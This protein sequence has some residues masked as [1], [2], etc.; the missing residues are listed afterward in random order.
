VVTVLPARLEWL[1]ALS[2]G[3]ETFTAR[4]GIPVVA[5]WVGFPDALPLAVDGARKDPGN[6]WGTHLFFDDQ[7]GALVGF[8]GWKDAPRAGIV[9][10]GYAVAPARQ[11][12]GIATDVVRELLRRA[13]EA[14]VDMVI[15]HTLPE[16]SASTA[17]LHKCGFTRGA[18]SADPDEGTVWRWEM[19]LDAL[20]ERAGAPAREN[21]TMTAIQQIPVSTIDGQQATLADHAGKVLLIVNVASKCGLTPQYEQLES[22]YRDRRDEG[23]EVL[24]FPANN[25]AGQEPGSNDEIVEFCESNYSV[26]FPLFS[27][28]SVTGDDKHPLYEALTE[29]VPRA[30]GDPDAFRERLR[31]HGMTPNEDPDILWNFEKFLVSK[32]GEVVRRFAPAMKPDD[33]TITAAIDEELAR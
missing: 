3:D 13:R 10:L 23:F 7:D 18:D 19:R 9:E 32:D 8:G 27:K 6:E 2:G 21:A 12:R 14:G 28:I 11:G 22:L 24:A 1:E 31:S 30:E 16:E 5:G 17:V 20:G 15:A 33:P 25:F 29:A 26:D 4:F